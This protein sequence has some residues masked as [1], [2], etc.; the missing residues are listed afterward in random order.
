MQ[1][2]LPEELVEIYST[3]TPKGGTRPVKSKGT[4]LI[5]VMMFI[6]I[7]EVQYLYPRLDYES[8]TNKTDHAAWRRKQKIPNLRS[9]SMVSNMHLP[10]YIFVVPINGAH[11]FETMTSSHPVDSDGNPLN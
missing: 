7:A 10:L 8:W 1:P 6:T 2:Y 11:S 3:P 9:L 5:D 4:V